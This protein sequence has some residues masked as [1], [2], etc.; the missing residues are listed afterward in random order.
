[1]LSNRAMNIQEPV[2]E[3]SPLKVV[4][5]PSLSSIAQNIKCYGCGEFP[6]TSVFHNLQLLELNEF[7]NISMYLT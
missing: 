6:S 5:T 2:V 1:M 4:E 7:V 3:Q